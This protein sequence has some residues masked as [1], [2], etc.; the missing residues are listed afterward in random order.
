MIPTSKFEILRRK[1][2]PNGSAIFQSPQF[3]LP[4]AAGT[5]VAVRG[6]ALG[7]HLTNSEQFDLAQGGSFYGHLTRRVTTGGLSLSDRVFGV[8]SAT[9]EGLE[10]PFSD[11][12]SVTVERA[13]ELECEGPNY[14]MLS[15]T[16]SISSGTTVPQNLSF[17]T[18]RLRI[19]QAGDVVCYTLAANNLTPT[20][21]GLTDLRIRVVA[22]L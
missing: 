5:T 21:D 15:G 22:A 6:L 16:G 19:A 18:G 10:S 8:T 1:T 20:D 13:E 3:Q 9:P 7:A 12:D 2:A 14:I 11:G 4:P 17:V